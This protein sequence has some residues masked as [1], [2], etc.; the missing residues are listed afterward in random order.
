MSFTYGEEHMEI[1]AEYTMSWFAG[2]SFFNTFSWFVGVFLKGKTVKSIIFWPCYPPIHQPKIKISLA[3]EALHSQAK[4]NGKPSRKSPQPPGETN[5]KTKQSPSWCT[6]SNT[7][8]CTPRNPESNT[9]QCSSRN[10]KSYIKM[11]P[12]WNP[13]SDTKLPLRFLLKGSAAV[14]RTSIYIYIYVYI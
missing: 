3:R 4:P 12:S 11:P 1:H 8:K 9:K 6:E 2:F 10:Q 7:K 14:L 5:T 13:E